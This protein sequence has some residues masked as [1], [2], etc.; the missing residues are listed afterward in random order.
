MK[1]LDSFCNHGWPVQKA[2]GG[3]DVFWTQLKYRSSEDGLRRVRLK[4][5]SKGRLGTVWEHPF[6]EKSYDITDI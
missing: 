5:H 2:K 6:S 4:L 3:E 1:A